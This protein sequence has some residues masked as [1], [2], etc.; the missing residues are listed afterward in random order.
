MLF[1][2]EEGSLKG[3]Q[4]SEAEE[5]ED[6]EIPFKIEHQSLASIDEEVEG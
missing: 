1:W 4:A 5:R 3:E 2:S 6:D